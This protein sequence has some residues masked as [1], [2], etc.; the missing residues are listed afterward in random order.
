VIFQP[1][2]EPEPSTSAPT[3]GPA[4]PPSHPGGEDRPTADAG[5][6]DI[7]VVPE[8][9]EAPT[10]D[11]PGPEDRD[12]AD[13]PR[14]GDDE[15]AITVGT[16]QKSTR[17]RGTTAAADQDRREQHD[18][19]EQPGPADP[20]APPEQPAVPTRA[21]AR[22]TAARKTTARKATAP[23]AAEQAAVATKTTRTGA[24][25]TKATARKKA[26]VAGA[27]A[28]GSAV[29]EP[30]T[31]DRDPAVAQTT[32]TT[33]GADEETTS[34]RTSWSAPRPS[35]ARWVLDHPGHAPEL[36]ALAAV[37]AFG[38]GVR[39][40]ADQLRVRYPGAPPAG[41]ARLA[42]RRYVRLSALGAAL[43]VGT[44]LFAP[45]V[46]RAAVAWAQ[47]ELALRLAAAYGHDP[48]ARDRAAD[49]LVLAGRHADLSSAQ[50]ALAAAEKVI[51]EAERVRASGGIG[52]PTADGPDQP[53][54][55]GWWP[56]AAT[57]TGSAEWLALRLLARQVPG[58][59]G[60]LAG[61]TGARATERFAAR[62]VAHYRTLGGQSQSNQLSGSSA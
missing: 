17:A 54:T 58:L 55:T 14:A 21:A 2:V 47:V 28:A 3:A 4:T 49:L 37:R 10:R 6:I 26:A 5:E 51:A 41:L 56:T 12:R 57:F 42:T 19:T 29:R 22:T 61:L 25:A 34:W 39:E 44:G 36:I 52:I 18:L 53:T 32:D 16:V 33:G 7:S 45:L 11:D 50:V 15:P 8:P 27:E 23:R 40:W 60:L 48:T 1:P 46:E 13:G 24:A 43:S 38:P 59:T 35:P 20:P 9:V 62:A 31:A 30:A